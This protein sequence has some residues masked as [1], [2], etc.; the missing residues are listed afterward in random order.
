MSYADHDSVADRWELAESLG[1][2]GIAIWSLGSEDP[3]NWA[4]LAQGCRLDVDGDGATTST[5]YRRWQLP[6]AEWPATRSTGPISTWT[7]TGAWMEPT[8]SRRPPAGAWGA[9]VSKGT[10]LNRIGLSSFPSGICL[11]VTRT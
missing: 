8:C 9:R 3:V 11:P 6:G 1:V 7:P 2:R 10:P 5:T 4:V